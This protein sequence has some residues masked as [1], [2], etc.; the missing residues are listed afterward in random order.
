MSLLT[1]NELMEINAGKGVGAFNT[2]NME[3][4]EAILEAAEEEKVPVIVMLYA[5]IFKRHGNALVP[6]IK[7]LVRDIKVPVCLHLDHALN[8]DEVVQ[9]IRMGF[10][11]VMI[12]ASALPIADNI[13]AT[14]KIVDIAHACNVSVEAELGCV[15]ISGDNCS[16]KQHT[17]PEQA[18]QFV[19]ETNVDALAIA[20]GNVHSGRAGCANINTDLIAEIRSK[21]SCMLVFHGGT[22][23]APGEIKDVVNAGVNKINFFTDLRR[24]YNI[25]LAGALRSDPESTECE[26]LINSAEKSVKAVVKEKMCLVSCS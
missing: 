14:K 8:F 11:S 1:L 16:D 4:T 19:Q 23:L 6:M 21:I 20:V 25:G 2:I 3:M 9:A 24:A 18:V 7:G 15:P 22:A 26:Q 12:D 5:P 10:S 17:D 13:A